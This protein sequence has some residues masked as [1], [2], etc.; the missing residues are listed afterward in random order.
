MQNQRAERGAAAEQLGAQYL[1]V[2]G[3][4]ILARNLR[5]KA[6]ELDLVCLDDGVLAIVEIRQREN[7]EYGGALG[8]VTRA[9]QR[10]IIRAAKY[11]LKREKQWRNFAMRF[12][13]LAIEGLP[14][15]AHRIEWVKDAFRERAGPT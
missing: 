11:F 9:K 8:S 3:L 2:R 7:L 14:D 5:C 4:K 10:K 1:K 13:V 12:D 15:G 6:G